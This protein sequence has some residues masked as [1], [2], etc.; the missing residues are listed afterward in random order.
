VL[1]IFVFIGVLR[2]PI[3]DVLALLDKKVILSDSD[4]AITLPNNITPRICF[5]SVGFSYP[6]ATSATLRN[7]NLTIEPGEKL[8]IIG[9]N[10]AG[11]ST[12]VKLLCRF[13]DPSSGSIEIDKIPLNQITRSSWYSMLG[14][15]FQDY[16][17][18]K[19]TV[20]ESISLGNVNREINPE[21]VVQ[22][23]KQAGADDFINA[24]EMSYEQ[25]LGAEFT[26]GKQP[27]VGQWQKLALSRLFY[28]NS[29]IMVLD[30]P[31]SS[32]D[33]EAEEKIFEQLESTSKEKTVILISHRFST[34][35]RADRIVVFEDGTIS[36][37]GNHD[38][39]IAQNGTYARLFNLQ[40]KG[41]K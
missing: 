38:Q 6:S 39:L 32:I 25:Q 12:F 5:K 28:R 4:K 15:I 27:S 30:E 33:A 13:Y 11:K 29:K 23:A 21:D 35:R 20:S 41:Y 19:F 10:G 24:W 8:A 2:F 37:L 14:V 34:V 31:T 7:I 40:A 9:L 1:Y 16:A 18:Y 22:A 36:E 3:G 26:N 17:Q